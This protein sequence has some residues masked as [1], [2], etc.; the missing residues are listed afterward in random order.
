MPVSPSA[1]RMPGIFPKGC[2]ERYSGEDMIARFSVT[3]FI[4][5]PTSSASH[6]TI[7]VLEPGAP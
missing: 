6:S 7:C 2:T 4:S 1:A 3:L 5:T